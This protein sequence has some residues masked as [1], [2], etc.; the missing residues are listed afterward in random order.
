MLPAHAKVLPAHTN[1]LAA[2]INVLPAHANVLPVHVDMLPAHSNMLPAHVD[3]LP[4]HSNMLPACT[5]VLPACTNVLPG[6][7]NVLPAYSNENALNNQT[8]KNLLCL[9]KLV[10]QVITLQSA[11]NSLQQNVFH[12]FSMN[13]LSNW[14]PDDSFG[15]CLSWGFRNTPYMFNL[16]K[17]WLRYLR[18]KTMNTIQN[19]DCSS[20]FYW[21]FRNQALSSTLNIPVNSSSNSKIGV[22]LPWGFQN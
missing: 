5:N 3:M 16:M 6:N 9:M 19:I 17:F 11:R 12:V 18:L 20:I 4:A 8:T 13:S 14:T 7:S 22:S 2:H 1:A 15:I 10:N 21:L